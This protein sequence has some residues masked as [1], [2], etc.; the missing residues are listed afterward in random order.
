MKNKTELDTIN[1]MYESGKITAEDRD[2]LIA[3]LDADDEPEEVVE[4][5]EV[6][7]ATGFGGLAAGLKKLGEE[8]K[9]LNGLNELE[10]LKELNALKDS[11]MWD[12]LKELNGLNELA[13]LS[14][15]K[16]ILGKAGEA[17]KKSF[18]S[19]SKVEANLD[20]DDDVSVEV[21]INLEDDDEDDE[22]DDEDDDDEDDDDDSKE[23]VRIR[24]K[25]VVVKR[26]NKKYDVPYSKL[27]IS[28]KYVNKDTVL[29]VSDGAI[30]AE[31]VVRQC[32]EVMDEESCKQLKDLI[33]IEF[34]GV[35]KYIKDSVVLKVSVSPDDDE[36]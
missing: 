2:K 8:L 26:I 19:M 31:K 6:K 4:M 32:E 18:E 30:N 3:A 25:N 33:K 34:T 36:D 5:S 11:K 1:R 29:K 9:D 24:G 21:N 12:E 17:V 10:G 27:K 13:G 15:L 28:V 7:D 16:D 22:D 20:E 23:I 14:E 35:Y